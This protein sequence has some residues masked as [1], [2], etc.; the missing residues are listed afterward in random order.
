MSNYGYGQQSPYQQ[1][2]QNIVPALVY[3]F[4][5]LVYILF[6]CPFEFWAAAT[7]RLATGYKNCS[8]DILKNTSRWPY[9]SF[10]KKVIFEFLIDGTIFIS[11]FIGVLAAI[12]TL[13]YLMASTKL[14]G[15]AF[16]AFFSIL[17]CTYYAPLGIS[18]FRD[19]LT[20]CLLPFNKYLS[21]VSKPA[22]QLDI[23]MR[24]H[25]VGAAAPV[26]A[27]RVEEYTAVYQAAPEAAAKAK[28]EAAPKFTIDPAWQPYVGTELAVTHRLANGQVESFQAPYQTFELTSNGA[29]DGTFLG[30][31][32]FETVNDVL[33]LYNGN[34]FLG[35]FRV[36]NPNNNG[37][38]EI[39]DANG[40][41]YYLYR[42]A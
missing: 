3:F 28:V 19:L 27:N 21:W 8:L 41:H 7:N 35:G 37:L 42:N 13:I 11:Y 30:A 10:C 6:I 25:P 23:D 32:R 2:S 38:V 5:S 4:K 34:R 22:Q 14:V 33:R 16:L 40:I 1:L 26:A 29:F 12:G 24:N 36:I 17:L 15:A 31:T 39:A 9:L 18:F 20:L